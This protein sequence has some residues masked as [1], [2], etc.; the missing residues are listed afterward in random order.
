MTADGQLRMLTAHSAIE[1]F[2]AMKH[3]TLLII[4]FA[5][6]AGGS[7]VWSMRRFIAS[8]RCLDRGGAWNS[9]LDACTLSTPN[10]RYPPISDTLIGNGPSAANAHNRTFR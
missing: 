10:G 6:L 2:S 1:K 4:I 7:A 3:R 5:L 8:D 9:N